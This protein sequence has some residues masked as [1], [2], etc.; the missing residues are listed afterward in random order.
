MESAAEE[1]SIQGPAVVSGAFL[2]C[3]KSSE[4]NFSIMPGCSQLQIL[5]IVIHF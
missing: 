5:Q 4:I 2:I 3:R 1:T